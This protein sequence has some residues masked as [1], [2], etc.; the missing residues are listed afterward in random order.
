MDFERIVA[1]VVEGKS[2]DDIET[3]AHS[4]S[5][6]S[7]QSAK[8]ISSEEGNVDS[9]AWLNR[10]RGQVAKAS[11]KSRRKRRDEENLIYEEN[12]RLRK[13][14]DEQLKHISELE[15][16]IR[17]KQNQ[18]SNG[19]LR[20]LHQNELLREQIEQHRVFYLKYLKLKDDLPEED[21]IETVCLSKLELEGLEF[22]FLYV[23]SLLSSSVNENWLPV[24]LD[25]NLFYVVKPGREVTGCFKFI[26]S[27]Q[28][29]MHLRL[30]MVV[31]LP[32]D[33]YE[34]HKNVD[35][36]EA[37]MKGIW[38]FWGSEDI[39]RTYFPTNRKF[40]IKKINIR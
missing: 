17:D 37:C 30:D 26:P 9:K 39:L 25:E 15:E 38:E 6:E 3:K 28:P 33:Y 7:K 36:M 12:K 24:S 18:I 29:R 35:P 11:R 19:D 13:E 4:D 8:N 16:K 23:Q 40:T 14:R 27:K 10:V 32:D 21:N 5:A 34:T 22:S 2:G 20:F 31:R 1:Q